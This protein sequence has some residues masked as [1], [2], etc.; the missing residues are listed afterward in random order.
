MP[1][2][3]HSLILFKCC[4]ISPHTYTQKPLCCVKENQFFGRPK[5][6]ISACVC[7]LWGTDSVLSETTGYRTL[8]E[9]SLAC[10]RV[11]GCKIS[12]GEQRK[13]GH[14]TARCGR[15]CASVTTGKSNRLL[16]KLKE[17]RYEGISEDLDVRAGFYL[18]PHIL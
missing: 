17:H 18:T 15:S 14:W 13:W 9:I 12:R 4:R 2:S 7:T 1:L 6:Q 5:L 11:H 10:Q 3:L 8:I 16:L